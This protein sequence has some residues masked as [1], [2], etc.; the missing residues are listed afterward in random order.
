MLDPPRFLDVFLPERERFL[1]VD[2]DL[3]ELLETILVLFLAL[4]GARID[5]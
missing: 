3:V 5:L 4:L 2:P 1:G